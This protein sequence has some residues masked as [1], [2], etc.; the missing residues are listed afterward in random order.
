M[1]VISCT[2]DAG[3]I[4]M[5]ETAGEAKDLVLVVDF[6]GLV[7]CLPSL[8]TQPFVFHIKLPAKWSINTTP[9]SWQRIP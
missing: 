3:F 1:L 5:V 4:F 6:F 8:Y 9:L 2:R 7:L